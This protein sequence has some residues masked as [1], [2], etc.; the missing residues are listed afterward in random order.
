MNTAEAM[1]LD[2]AVESLLGGDEPA[3][4]SADLDE[5]VE[6]ITEDTAEEVDAEVEESEDA[7]EGEPEAEYD[8]EDTDDES[9]TDEYDE[10]DQ[11]EPDTFTVKVDGEE[12]AVTLDDL[13]RSYSGQGK[14][15]KGMQEAAEMRKQAQAAQQQAVAVAQRLQAEF[16]RVQQE[17]FIA[18][19]QEP[20]RELYDSDPMAYFD[21]KMDY[22]QQMKAYTAQQQSLQQ[23]RAFL[24]H[25]QQVQHQEQVA[26]ELEVLREKVPE[27]GD[28]ETAAQFQKDILKF[29]SDYGYS[30]E[31]ISN[32]M[33][34]RAL[35]VLRDAMRWRKS[36]SKRS[37]VEQK[38]KGARKVIKPQA[39]KTQTPKAK[40]A[41][42]A[43]ANL[44]K[45]GTLDA[46]VAAL[47]VE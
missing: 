22:D 23:Q 1:D 15:Q 32:V 44:K 5:A 35:M 8:D 40:K 10:P 34:H 47:G 2:R 26:R 45:L 25:Q 41:Q 20:T 9:E 27:L 6:A 19:P 29:G 24:A 33:D 31:E 36:Q 17:G 21:A 16:Q 14:I 3:T 39:K 38:A 28:A 30:D 4:E 37:Q 18:P 12:V 13:K 42:Q 43:K 7:D 46:A 11:T